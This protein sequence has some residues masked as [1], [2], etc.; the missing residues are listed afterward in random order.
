M[1]NHKQRTVTFLTRGQIDFLD[2][3]GKD[4]LFLQG[5]RLSRAEALSELVNFLMELGLDFRSIDFSKQTLSEALL[6]ELSGQE[7]EDKQTEEETK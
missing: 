2:K 6:E 3:L 7:K 1:N 4:A 5:C